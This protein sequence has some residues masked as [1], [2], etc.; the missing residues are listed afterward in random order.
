MRAP[1]WVHV[2]ADAVRVPLPLPPSPLDGQH[3]MGYMKRT[4]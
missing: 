3:V 4:A 1:R 2:G